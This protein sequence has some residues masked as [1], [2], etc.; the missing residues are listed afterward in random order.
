MVERLRRRWVLAP[1]RVMAPVA[2]ADDRLR[3]TTPA[4][5]AA[6]AEL[7]AA[8]YEPG[9]L[10]FDPDDD[11]TE[12]LRTWRTTDDADDA[13]SQVFVVDGEIVGASMIAVDL[14]APFV[15]ELVVAPR[16]QRRS[17]GRRLLAASLAVLAS[18]NVDQVAAWITIG[19][20][21]SETLFEHFGFRPATPPHGRALGVGLHWAARALSEIDTS[22]ALATAIESLAPGRARVWIVGSTPEE[23]RTVTV[24]DTA[25]EL[26]W[27]SPDDPAVTEVAAT[28]VPLTGATYLATRRP[29]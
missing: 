10:D 5:D 11:P 18:R 19:N 12:E 21:A 22:A 29:G 24:R 4:D 7:L 28:A 25:V 26:C 1:V 20:D 9:H 17:V 14:G 23:D 15:Y 16:W 8:A 2:R 13:A 3:A 27:R 6:L